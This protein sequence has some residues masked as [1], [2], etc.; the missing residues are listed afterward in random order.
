M[1]GAGATRKMV[2]KKRF[3]FA[4]KKKP[5]SGQETDNEA[6]NSERKELK[7]PTATQSQRQTQEERLGSRFAK[8]HR[9]KPRARNLDFRTLRGGRGGG[10]SRMAFMCRGRT[11]GKKMSAIMG[12]RI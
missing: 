6:C 11:S 8:I 3:E 7:L 5:E 10:G 1:G 9:D 4:G 12:V 2:K